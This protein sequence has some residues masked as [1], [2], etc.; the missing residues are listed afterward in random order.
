MLEGH[1]TG[2]AGMAGG[3]RQLREDSNTDKSQFKSD[4]DQIR[5]FAAVLGSFS[6]IV[7]QK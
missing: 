1:T 4:I 3:I 6:F 5:F 7:E 2:T